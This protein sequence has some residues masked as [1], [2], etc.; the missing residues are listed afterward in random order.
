MD[1]CSDLFQTSENRDEKSHARNNSS[2]ATDK[3]KS[4]QSKLCKKCGRYESKNH[5][6]PCTT[7]DN[8][9]DVNK[10]SVDFLSSENGKHYKDD[11]KT[12]LVMGRR[13]DVTSRTF[14]TETATSTQPTK[15]QNENTKNDNNISV[16][17]ISPPYF[18]SLSESFSFS[19]S[20]KSLKLRL[21]A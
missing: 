7:F 16:V 11:T 15:H 4:K 21:N 20:R 2:T 8:H 18:N 17:I 1:Q 5:I 13:Y 12:F 3:D 6:I 10:Q 9:P 19:L 14:K